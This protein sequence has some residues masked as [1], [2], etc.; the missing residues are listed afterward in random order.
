MTLGVFLRRC[1]DVERVSVVGLFEEW[2]LDHVLSSDVFHSF[3][4]SVI[5]HWSVIGGGLY[6]VELTIWLRN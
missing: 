5:D 1:S 4:K 3:R 6:P 2:T